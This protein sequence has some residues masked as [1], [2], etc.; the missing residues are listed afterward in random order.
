MKFLLYDNAKIALVSNT[1]AIHESMA[2]DLN[3]AYSSLE[4]EESEI[5]KGYKVFKN[6]LYHLE[7]QHNLNQNIN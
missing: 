4:V 6:N 5:P 1:S 7:V 2:Y 3:R